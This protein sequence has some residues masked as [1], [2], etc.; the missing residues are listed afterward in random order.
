MCQDFLCFKGW[1]TFHWFINRILFIYSPH[2]GHLG[3]F[4]LSAIV[5]KFCH[6]NW[7]SSPDDFLWNIT[8]P[9][10]LIS[11]CPYYRAGFE[12]TAEYGITTSRLLVLNSEPFHVFFPHSE[13]KIQ[14]LTFPTRLYTMG[15]QKE[16]NASK[17]TAIQSFSLFFLVWKGVVCYFSLT[18]RF[19]SASHHFMVFHCSLDP[20]AWPAWVLRKPNTAIRQTTHCRIHWLL[21]SKLVVR[22]IYWENVSEHRAKYKEEELMREKKIGDRSRKP[23]KGLIQHAGLL[24]EFRRRQIGSNN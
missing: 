17:M 9:N 19:C 12:L 11:C 20:I 14:S 15:F 4:P 2:D 23:N 1:I 10:P 6:S 16:V 22:K 5:N 24:L 21:R 8:F 18:E 7:E 3:C 13:Y